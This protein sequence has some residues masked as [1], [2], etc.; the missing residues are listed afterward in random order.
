MKNTSRH[1]QHYN[2]TTLQHYSTFLQHLKI[3]IIG[4]ESTGKTTLCKELSSYFGSQYITEYA[5][6]YIAKLDR[7]YEYEDLL[8][9]AKEQLSNYNQAKK[10]AKKY[11]FT[12]TSLLTMELWSRDKFGKC[13]TWIEE[14]I[15][16]EC[17]DL[18][19][20]CD[21]D[22]PWQYDEQREDENRRQ[23]I[24]EM[25]LEYLNKYKFEYEIISG[26][27]NERLNNA[28]QLINNHSSN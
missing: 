19:L 14:Q 17:F 9:I 11:I 8:I 13:D 27:G 7:T 28:V 1:I 12:D 24:F 22:L 5:R 26:L 6:E 21:V 15:S 20:L 10:F 4:P 3:A 18:Y 23:E 25:H 16:N 2:T